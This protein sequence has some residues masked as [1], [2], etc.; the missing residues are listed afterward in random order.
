VAEVTFGDERNRN[1]PT[2]AEFSEGM[3]HG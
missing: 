1:P 2:E 3:Q